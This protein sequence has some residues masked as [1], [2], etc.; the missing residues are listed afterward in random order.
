MAYGLQLFTGNG[1]LLLSDS[2]LM[3][4]RVA[5]FVLT[6]T[7]GA[8]SIPGVS[9][10]NGI[11]L[12]LGSGISDGWRSTLTLTLGLSSVTWSA[13]QNVTGYGYYL[14]VYKTR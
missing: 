4:R 12:F 2:D 14:E 9:P 6:G 3:V 10:E 8:F 13:N 7:G 5:S 1:A 11:A